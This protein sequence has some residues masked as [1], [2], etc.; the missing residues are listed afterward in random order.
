[1]IPGW[2]GNLGKWLRRIEV[3]DQPWQTR[4]ETSKYADLWPMVARE[5]IPS[6]WTQ[7]PW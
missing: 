7:S 1:V 5:S 2:E 3:G 6:S 4:E